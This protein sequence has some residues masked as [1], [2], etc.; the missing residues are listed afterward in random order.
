MKH[1]LTNGTK[2]NQ[3]LHICGPYKRIYCTVLE[4]RVAHRKWKETKQL[5]SILPGPAVPGSCLLSFH[6]LWAILSTS[7]VYISQREGQ[8]LKK[9]DFFADIIQ[10]SSH[11]LFVGGEAAP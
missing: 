4:L 7:T 9:I 8:W 3:T 5:P 2:Q 10:G 6:I 11:R 1:P